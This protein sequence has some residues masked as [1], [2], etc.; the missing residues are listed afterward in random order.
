MAT[1]SYLALRLGFQFIQEKFSRDIKK[2]KMECVE[3]EG[4]KRKS[5]GIKVNVKSGGLASQKLASWIQL[6]PSYS[7]YSSM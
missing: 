3:E 5:P 4:G 1:Y 2:M 6:V 7:Q